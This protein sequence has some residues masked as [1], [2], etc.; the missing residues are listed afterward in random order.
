MRIWHFGGT[1]SEFHVSGPPF[2]SLLFALRSP[3]I[4]LYHIGLWNERLSDWRVEEVWR[5]WEVWESEGGEEWLEW[6]TDVT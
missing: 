4:R 6:D 3:P 1:R 5:R 2:D